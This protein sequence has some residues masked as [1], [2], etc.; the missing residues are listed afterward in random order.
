MT[1]GPEHHNHRET[2]LKAVPGLLLT[3]GLAIVAFG[4]WWFLANTWL[5]FSALLWAF[6][7]S[8]IAANLVPALSSKR[9]HQG[10]DLS[11]THLLKFAIAL[12]GLTF[13]ASVWVE[14]GGMGIAAV[15]MNLLFT[16]AFGYV[17]CRY[18]LKLDGALPLLLMVGTS[19]C[20]ATAIAATGPA[21]RAKAEE[22]GLAVAVV[23]LFGLVAMFGYPLLYYGPLNH[24]LNN[25]PLAY[26]MWAGMG[27]HE[28]AQVIAAGSQVEGAAS[29]AI[30]AKFIRI[31]MI[32]P[33]V[34]ASLLMSRGSS[35]KASARRIRWATPWFAVAFIALTLVNFGLDSLPIRSWWADFNNGYLKSGVTFLL[36]WSFAAVGLKVRFSAI[37]TVGFKAIV[38]GIVVSVVAGGSA[39]LLV[40]YL[41][42]PLSG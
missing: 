1:G 36:A 8:I 20:G 35:S 2:L 38:G 6:M 11:S 16:S 24:W 15:I 19:I 22:M 29:I 34:F 7:Y 37:R 32:G 5:K 13:S 40:K 30:S 3:L 10:I 4:T 28:T 23:T 33:M 14:L 12:L 42:I 21:L 18:V 9:F 17:F 26:G 39:L 27:I 31:F 25:L 41:W